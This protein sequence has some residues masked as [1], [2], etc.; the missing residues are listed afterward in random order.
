MVFK[1]MIACLALTWIIPFVV[2]MALGIVYWACAGMT[3]IIH[4]IKGD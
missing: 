2:S 1:V 4:F 3:Q